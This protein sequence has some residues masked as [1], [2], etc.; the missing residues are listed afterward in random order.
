MWLN[1]LIVCMASLVTGFIIGWVFGCPRRWDA[2]TV[3]SPRVPAAETDP[4]QHLVFE[5]PGRGPLSVD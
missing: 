2:R 3:A 4:S 5:F 1:L